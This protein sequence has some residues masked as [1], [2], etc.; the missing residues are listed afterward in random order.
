MNELITAVRQGNAVKW[1]SEIPRYYK[2]V[3]NT[4]MYS[5]D[6]NEWF[7]SNLDAEALEITLHNH[8]TK[9]EVV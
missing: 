4:V 9:F 2:L 1:V 5:D 6:C 3:D 7:T 8:H